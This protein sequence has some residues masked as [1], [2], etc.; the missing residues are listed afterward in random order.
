MYLI[1]ERSA[2][3]VN[4]NFYP[5]FDSSGEPDHCFTGII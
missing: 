4:R 1:D 2:S 3:P 5:I